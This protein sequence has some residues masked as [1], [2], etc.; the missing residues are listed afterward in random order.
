MNGGGNPGGTSRNVCLVTGGA[1]FLGSQVVR[2]L[3][4]AHRVVRVLDPCALDAPSLKPL[5]NRVELI[6]GSCVD[7]VVLK[8]V[9]V[10]LHFAGSSLPAASNLDPAADVTMGLANNVQLFRQ[11][12]L[13]GVRKVIFPSSGGTVYGIPRSLPVSEL[14]PTNPITSYGI[15]KLAS[16]K[17]LALFERLHGMRFAALRFGNPYGEGQHP[18]RGFGVIA[19]FLGAVF[20]GRPLEIWGTETACATSFMLKTRSTRSSAPSTTRDRNVSSI[21][22]A[23]WVRRSGTWL[24]WCGG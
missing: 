24:L 13:S 1:G 7:E 11:A 14:D 8:D 20:T 15:V 5:A 2:R 19:S 23:A 18:F 3:V 9:D 4:T 17:Y 12:A 22:E 10:L 16:E 6:A 21:S